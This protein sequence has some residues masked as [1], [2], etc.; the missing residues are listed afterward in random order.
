MALSKVHYRPHGGMAMP[1]MCVDLAYPGQN[2]AAPVFRFTIISV[3]RA[4]A[5]H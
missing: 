5:Y 3:A 4:D 1:R 2:R